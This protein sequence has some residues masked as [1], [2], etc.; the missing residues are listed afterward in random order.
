[1]SRRDQN[2]QDSLRKRAREMSPKKDNDNDNNEQTRHRRTHATTRPRVTEPS[3]EEPTIEFTTIGQPVRGLDIGEAASLAAS[4]SPEEADTR[5]RQTFA[6]PR[7]P[8]MRTENWVP[9]RT[10][11]TGHIDSRGQPRLRE[12][13]EEGNLMHMSYVADRHFEDAK[14]ARE[15]M[16][17]MQKDADRAAYHDRKHQRLSHERQQMDAQQRTFQQH[18]EAM[19]AQER[20][21]MYANKREYDDR[22]SERQT[23][24]RIERERLEHERKQAEMQQRAI[25][26]KERE[27]ARQRQQELQGVR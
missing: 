14:H 26:E 7:A 5:P 9:G 15:T 18:R 1:M 12:E 27:N 19:Q 21:K 17:R 25:M 4:E 20:M 11:R 23:L 10:V 8:T 16:E 2:L 22:E 3:D 6:M 24:A 13:V